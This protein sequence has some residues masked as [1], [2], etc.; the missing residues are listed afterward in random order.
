LI[1]LKGELNENQDESYSRYMMYF[2]PEALRD[3]RIISRTLDIAMIDFV[4]SAL[5]AYAY[6][7]KSELKN[8]PP[9]KNKKYTGPRNGTHEAKRIRYIML[10]NKD[11]IDKTRDIASLENRRFSHVCDEALNDFI[12]F[13]KT[14]RNLKK[15]HLTLMLSE[16]G[17][18]LSQWKH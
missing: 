15:H 9:R 13:T 16:E 7:K 14:S 3:I 17:S 6:K 12:E 8:I 2:K 1:G 10:L 4:E 18:L 11:V 5:D